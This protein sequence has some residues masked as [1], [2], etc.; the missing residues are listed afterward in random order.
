MGSFAIRPYVLGDRDRVRHICFATGY[1]GDPADWMWRDQESFATL[2]SGYYTDAEPESALVVEVDGEVSGYLLGCVD[3]ATA[4]DPA[5]V[6]G[7]DVLR[8]WLLLRPGTARFIWRSLGDG[9]LDALRRRPLPTP[10]LDPRWPAHLHINLLP[11]ARG[12]GAGSAMM[13]EWLDRL[14]ERGTPG[15]HLE[16]LAENHNAIAF[17]EAMGFVREGLP[18]RAPGMRDRAGGRLHVQLM[19]QPLGRG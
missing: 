5:K 2:F 13:R 8:R 15:C 17:F 19:V 7:R 10:V 16:T 6:I 14:R 11:K 12:G 1:M 18:L 9:A 3:S 4:W